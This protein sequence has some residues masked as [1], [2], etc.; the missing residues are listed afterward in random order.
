MKQSVKLEE[1]LTTLTDEIDSCMRLDIKSKPEILLQSVT[2]VI[3]HDQLIVEVKSIYVDL[4]M[5][6]VK[7][8]EVDEKHFMKAQKKTPSCQTKSS[9]KH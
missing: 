8:I 1:N 6:K 5:L 7:C 2:R 4:I 3:S 9:S